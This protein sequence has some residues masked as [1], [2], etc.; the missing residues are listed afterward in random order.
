MKF[1][2]KEEQVY[3]PSLNGFMEKVKF[4]ENKLINRQFFARFLEN[5]EEFNNSEKISKVNPKEITINLF[6]DLI[7]SICFEKRAVLSSLNNKNRPEFYQ[8]L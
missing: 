6:D 2:S 1:H 4:L 8:V 7:L 5:I 3:L